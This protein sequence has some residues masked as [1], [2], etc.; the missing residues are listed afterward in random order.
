MRESGE[1]YLETVLKLSLE[2]PKVRLTDVANHLGV[3]KPSASRAMKNLQALGYIDQESYGAIEL[4]AKG[5][6]RASQIYKRHKTL[7]TFLEKVLGIDSETA[8]ADA[9]RMEHILSNHTM[10]KLS[11]FVEEHTN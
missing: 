3:S 6:I 8:E 2:D 4:T 11:E 7:R 5:Y 1:D 10:E 9:C